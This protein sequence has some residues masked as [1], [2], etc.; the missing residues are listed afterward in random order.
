MKKLILIPAILGIFFSVD[1]FYRIRREKPPES[2]LYVPK[3]KYVKVMVMNFR[4]IVAD[5]LLARALVYFGA[6]FY[7]KAFP[8]KWLYN[9]FDAATTVDPFNR[10]A[11]MMG[12]RLLTVRDVHL[13]IKLLKKGM[14]YHSNYWKFPEMVGFI[15]F[16]YLKDPAKA[17]IW[18]DKASRLPGHPPYVPSLASKFYTEAGKYRA[19]I[20]VLYNFYITTKD[21]R[22][23]AIF[24]K[25]IERLQ[26]RLMEVER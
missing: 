16:F 19:A 20:R 9:L 23:K 6:H 15:Y 7:E 5:Y 12:A 24:K 17:A 26:K 2:I 14:K 13:S 10:E 4:E 18:Y 25:D 1:E 3:G 21:K 11:F 8:Y 22:L